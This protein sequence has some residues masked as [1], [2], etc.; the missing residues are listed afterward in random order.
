[1]SKQLS[2]IAKKLYYIERKNTKNATTTFKMT[3]LLEKKK[4]N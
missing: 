4:L 3:L 1:M 2:T